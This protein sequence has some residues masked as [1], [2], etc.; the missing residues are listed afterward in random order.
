[1]THTDD[2]GVHHGILSTATSA[3]GAASQSISA[4]TDT[5]V[6]SSGILLP[7]YGMQVGQTLRWFLS[8]VKTATGTVAPVFT[9]RIGAAQSTSDT[10]RLV[11]TGGASTSNAAGSVVVVLVQVRTVSASGVIVGN[12]NF[13][14]AAFGTGQTTTVVSSTFD[15]TST[16]GGQ[17]VGISINTGTSGPAYTVD[18]VRSELVQ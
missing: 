8:L 14:A 4:A 3:S 16:I 1:M 11:I 6:T 18:G 2:S 15:N 5:Y 17:Y 13:G 9:I 7:A 10:S 12:I